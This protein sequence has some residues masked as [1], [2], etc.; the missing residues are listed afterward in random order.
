MKSKEKKVQTG[1]TIE[2]IE[3]FFYLF[4]K[5]SIHYKSESSDIHKI[6]FIKI[7]LEIPKHFIL[8]T[9]YSLKVSFFYPF[10]INASTVH[11]ITQ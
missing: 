10:N 7:N 9:K 6:I 1:Y 8:Y 11:G 3:F 2:C 5:I 4:E